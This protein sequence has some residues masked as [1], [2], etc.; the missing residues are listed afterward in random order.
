MASLQLCT[1][2][3]AYE[4]APDDDLRWD[5]LVAQTVLSPEFAE[6][7]EMLKGSGIGST[8]ATS[9]LSNLIRAG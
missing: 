2:Q 9:H 6:A 7:W 4:A 8:E 3:E 5:D 1:G